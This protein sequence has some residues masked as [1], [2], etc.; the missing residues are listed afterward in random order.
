MTA[1][2]PRL[3]SQRHTPFA[4]KKNNADLG[5]IANVGL[6]RAT[7]VNAEASDDLDLLLGRLC[8]IEEQV[9]L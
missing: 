4:W 2:F 9:R 8:H 3:S 7:G 6:C 1:T 5:P